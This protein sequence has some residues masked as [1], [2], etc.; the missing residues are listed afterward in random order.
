[1]KNSRD[2]IVDIYRGIAI[3]LI[4][5]GHLFWTEGIASYIYSFHLPLFFIATGFFISRTAQKYTFVKYLK[6][7]AF[8][9]LLIYFLALFTYLNLVISIKYKE[10]GVLSAFMDML[11]VFLLSTPQ[12]VEE[13]SYQTYYWFLPFFFIYSVVL[14][15]IFKYLKKYL[16]IVYGLS[17]LLSFVV[18][19]LH[20]NLFYDTKKIP[21]SAD[22]LPF[23]IPLGILGYTIWN[24][25]KL[26][27]KNYLY[28]LPITALAGMLG[29]IYKTDLRILFIS[30][31]LMYYLLALNGSLFVLTLSKFLDKF[32]SEGAYSIKSLLVFLG[33]NSLIVYLIHGI[34]YPIWHGRMGSP[35]G[36][37]TLFN[38]TA[39]SM[40]IVLTFVLKYFLEVISFWLKKRRFVNS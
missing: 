38:L 40:T 28:I 9:I 11:R 13:S 34:V 16:V 5:A 22:I 27:Y 30:N 15:L 33:E 20:T 26:I 2:K 18:Y 1:M 31:M 25:R 24:Y 36:Y 21:W 29:F 17:I 8:S 39:I 6:K 35:S 19:F 12:I 10:I 37:S 23:A 7:R 14:F 3:I 32:L 4:L